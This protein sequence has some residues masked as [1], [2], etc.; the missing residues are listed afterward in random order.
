[1]D[2]LANL[3]VEYSEQYAAGE[4]DLIEFF[5]RVEAVLNTVDWDTLYAEE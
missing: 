3:I 2:K 1:M 5:G 4:M